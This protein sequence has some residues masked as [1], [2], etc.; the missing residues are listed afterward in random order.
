MLALC[1]AAVNPRPCA[2]VACIATEMLAL[3]AVP[4]AVAVGIVKRTVIAPIAVMERAI[5]AVVIT[6]IIFPLT[7]G[8]ASA[9][10]VTIGA[11]AE[12]GQPGKQSGEYSHGLKSF[13]DRPIAAVTHGSAISPFPEGSGRATCIKL[14]SIHSR[15]LLQF[16]R[17]G[18]GVHAS[19]KDD[20][21]ESRNLFQIQG[22]DNCRVPG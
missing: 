1:T 3:V 11:A 19:E 10:M 15:V 14:H 20:G 2:A 13:V 17:F 4:V 16:S 18:W 9:V 7:D 5:G 22:G 12:Q 21:E 8:D 6:V